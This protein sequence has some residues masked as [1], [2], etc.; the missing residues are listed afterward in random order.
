MWGNWIG[1]KR[2]VGRGEGCNGVFGR[3]VGGLGD[4]NQLSQLH[5]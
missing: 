4:V 1:M 3:G 2:G 5:F